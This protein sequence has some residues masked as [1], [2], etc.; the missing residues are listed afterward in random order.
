MIHST[1][2]PQAKH[3][4]NQPY[5]Y[6]Y[7]FRWFTLQPAGMPDIGRSLLVCVSQQRTTD[8]LRERG[9]RARI[10]LGFEYDGVR[11]TIGLDWDWIRVIL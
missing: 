7:V 9:Y 4:P 11:V 10:G 6:E 3:N 2:I 5:V 1:L 8:T